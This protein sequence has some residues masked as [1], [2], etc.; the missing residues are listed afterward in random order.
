MV[1]KIDNHDI[2]HKRNLK[3][4]EAKI[5]A[6]YHEAIREA[7]S[8]SNTVGK[9]NTDKPFSFDEYPITRKR[10]DDL[11]S[12][13]KSKMETIVMNGIKAEWTLANDKNNIIVSKVFG[14]HVD[15]LTP[16]QQKK[17]FSTNDNAMKAFQQ[18]KV[19]GLNLSDRVWR[20]TEQFKEEIEMGLDIGIRS[21]RSAN[22]MSRD[23]R[24]YLKHPDKL[25]R[26]VRDEH[27]QLHLSK[28]AKAFHPG[29]GVYRSSYKNARRLASTETNIAYRT[30]D[31]L[32]WQQMDFVVGI[33]IHLS[34]N[35]TLNGKPFRD[36]CD[37]LAGSYPK[38]FKFTGWHPHCRCF[39]TSILK[40]QKEMDEDTQKI[41]KGE[42]ITNDSEN[43]VK[44][45]PEAFKDWILNNKGRIETAVSMPYFISDNQ[46]IVDNILNPKPKPLTTIEKARL[47]QQNRTAEQI[48]NIKKLWEERKKKQE[49]IRKAAANILKVAKDY[50]EV[51][52]E[53]LQKIVSTDDLNKM[54]S[55]TKIVAKAISEMKKQEQALSDH[56]LNVHEWHKQYTLEELKDIHAM[57]EDA[58]SGIT[59]SIE[60]K[61]YTL[62]SQIETI[63]GG[64]LDAELGKTRPVVLDSLKAKLKALQSEVDKKNIEKSVI[65]ALG[66]NDP[67][68][69]KLALELQK[70]LL[71]DT[72]IVELRQKAEN[73]NNEI[74][75][76]RP[77]SQGAL[78]RET[79]DELKSRFGSNLPKTLSNLD[80]AIKSYEHSSNYG[81]TAKAHK[82]EI[83]DLMR[84]LFDKHDFGMNIAED[85][86]EK[87]LT[88]KFKNTFETGYSGGYL[89]STKTTG[90]IEVTHGRLIA[91]HKLFG[92]SKDLERGQLKRHE[93]E[94]Y[95]SLL[96]HN[97]LDSINKYN[98]AKDY[99][100]VEV[101]F[102]KDKVIATWT[103]GDS[104]CQRW[105]P[106]LCSDPKACSFDN[107]P[108][109]PTTKDVDTNDLY[110]L[111]RSHTYD[112]IELQYH[113]ELTIDCVESLAFPYDITSP[114]WKRELEI[115]KGWK[116]TGVKVYYLNSSGG[117]SQL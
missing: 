9:V 21:G 92:L 15:K 74:T 37:E 110:T 26:R 29:Q 107:S 35:H 5:D 49:L 50:G 18:R 48:Q 103:A 117:L 62:K 46:D 39:A 90:E 45:V 86:I 14:R 30:S 105:Q 83:E 17:Y 67:K 58:H 54:K 100:N 116:K 84:E 93:Y 104:L 109:T 78:R 73:L 112:Y 38:N 63:E 97:I 6:I 41:L 94:K 76:I 81:D 53:E 106:S 69:K 2:K 7:V 113:G 27:G 8:I 59:G 61:Y 36:I 98:Y 10:I 25:F 13:L 79:L 23:L 11:L 60:D 68:V 102:K 22:E 51:D 42:P 55:V 19:R 101:R 16:E 95:G 77:Q 96:D 88:S 28:N 24:Q 3:L 87:V 82:E 80:K 56:I 64:L 66:I 72:P 99:G 52:Y 33:E 12:G 1:K 89:G 34:N 65:F 43:T 4:Y 20:Y 111:R 57:L 70:I 108:R 85:K 71:S 47:R 115:A 75:K 31:H 40:T 32:R 44:D 114:R 91:G